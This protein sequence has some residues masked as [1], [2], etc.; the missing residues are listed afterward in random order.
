MMSEQEAQF[1]SASSTAKDTQT[2]CCLHFSF[3]DIILCIV[4]FILLMAGL[5]A[6]LGGFFAIQSQEQVN[7]QD[8]L[9]IISLQQTTSVQSSIDN[10]VRVANVLTGFYSSVSD[11]LNIDFYNTFLPF[12]NTSNCMLPGMF[13]ISMAVPV[14]E[15][16]RVAFINRVRSFNGSVFTN[17]NFTARDAQSRMI[18][19]PLMPTYWP[20]IHSNPTISVI[21]FNL[22]SDSVR[23]AVINKM[24]L[25][26]TITASQRVNLAAIVGSG[27]LI[28]QPIFSKIQT[29]QIIGLALSSLYVDQFMQIALNT[30][31]SSD[32][33]MFMSD[34]SVGN[35]TDPLSLL[36]S[37]VTQ[38]QLND[39]YGG[40]KLA[41]MNILDYKSFYNAARFKYSVSVTVADRVWSLNFVGTSSFVIDY[42]RPEKWIVLFCV[43]SAAI[44][45]GFLIVI[46]VKR[47]QYTQHVRRLSSMKVNLLQENESRLKQLLNKIAVQ[48][49]KMR[50]TVDAIPEFMIVITKEG[51]IV[52]TN[53]SFD[54]KFRFSDTEIEK[55]VNLSTVFPNLDQKFWT[56]MKPSDVVDTEA[57]ARFGTLIPVQ[58][59]VRSLTAETGVLDNNEDDGESFII[60]AKNMTDKDLLMDD[61]RK[62]E[63]EVMNMIEYVRFDAQFLVESFR[64]QLLQ[65]CRNEKSDENILFL[66]ALLQYKKKNVSDRVEM[67]RVIYEKYIKAS[68]PKQLN[69]NQELAATVGMKLI[70]S[71]GD[72]DLFKDVEQAVK[73]L[74]VTDAYPR[75]L[76]EQEETSMSSHTEGTS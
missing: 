52:R 28:M 1:D 51:Q 69:I 74:V 15:S 3:A 38:Q 75:F 41:D 8:A 2:R 43:L 67:Q 9:R 23:T 54:Q 50:S 66:E 76:K 21:G 22:M 55:G 70:K 24:V 40:K 10:L 42:V 33:T 34:E 14:Q 63:T 49:R 59:S 29:N 20:V 56:T 36:Y 12:V 31:S 53:A 35:G 5:G 68:A 37:T 57:K 61:V 16:D 46:F 30:F 7:A 27:V 4:V 72:I 32:I 62:H 17:F 26:G 73:V 48:E 60:L 58:V 11:P 13:A 6:G 47:L 19:A 64:R 18:P 39:Y 44:I 45:I 71:V 25:S 65:F